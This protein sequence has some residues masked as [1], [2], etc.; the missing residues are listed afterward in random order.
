MVPAQ[1]PLPTA[2][3]FPFHACAGIQISTLMSESDGGVSVVA[4]RQKAGIWL[5]CGT[6]GPLPGRMNPPAGTISANVIEVFG[7]VSEDK[8]SHDVVVL[9]ACPSTFSAGRTAPKP[10]VTIF[11][12]SSA[13]D[14]PTG[15]CRRRPARLQHNAILALPINLGQVLRS[16]GIC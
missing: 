1:P 12:T 11:I 5:N 9:R 4:T 2:R 6:V 7:S 3:N 16:Q 8:L 15:I 14:V 10:P 13:E